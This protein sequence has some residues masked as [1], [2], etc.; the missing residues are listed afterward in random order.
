MPSR[1]TIA[2]ATVLV[3]TAIGTLHVYWTRTPQY[4]LLHIF[5]VYATADHEAV[6]VYI[7]KEQPLKKRLHVQ[8]RT[9]NV[10]RHLADLQN[11]TLARAY[12]VT[13][14]ASRIEGT[15]AT[16]RIKVGEM[17]YQLRFDEQIDG[18]WKLL[19][20]E[21]RQAFSELVMKAMTPNHFMVFAR[22]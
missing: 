10:I 22:L 3:F 4:T 8:R 15:T 21:D 19:D 18:S 12:R 17:P 16:L 6:A 20:F 9:E 13:V 7:E 14:E 11:E 2:I 5:N 1:I